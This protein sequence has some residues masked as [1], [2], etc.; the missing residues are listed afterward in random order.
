M[1]SCRLTRRRWVSRVFTLFSSCVLRFLVIDLREPR[2]SLEKISRMT[3]RR[4]KG[5]GSRQF[6]GQMSGFVAGLK[7]RVGNL[8]SRN[9]TQNN[10]RRAVSHAISFDAT[11]ALLAY[12]CIRPGR[13]RRVRPKAGVTGSVGGRRSRAN[14]RRCSLLRTLLRKLRESARHGYRPCSCPAARSSGTNE[15]GGLIFSLPRAFA[16]D[17]QLRGTAG[18]E[19]STIRLLICRRG[20]KSQ[21]SL[22]SRLREY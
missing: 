7:S 15:P 16:A 20:N 1:R 5:G 22:S 2:S 9:A 14:A 13:V 6:A 19:P 11:R 4:E 10:A 17:A 3:G 18:R 21:K 8:D 12:Y